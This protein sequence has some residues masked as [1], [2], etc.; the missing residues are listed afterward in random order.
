[1][2]KFY[3]IILI[4]F[5]AFTYQT[6][7]QNSSFSFSCVRDTT[8]TLCASSCFTLTARIPDIH[9]SSN[10]YVVNS[11]TSQPDGC[12]RQYIS[13]STPGTSTSIDMD[14]RYSDNIVLPFTF[15]FFGTDFTSL[16]ISGNGYLSLDPLIVD[17]SFSHW[18]ICDDG[19]GFLTFDGTP[20]DLPS[21]LYD[22][23]LIMGP[24]HDMDI[25]ENTSPNSRIKYDVV[26]VAPH[27]RWIVSYYKLPLYQGVSGTCNTLI[28]NTH[29]IVLYEGNGVVEVFVNSVENCPDW[30]LGRAMIGM[31]NYNRDQGIMAPGRAASDPSWGQ[32]NMNETW[33]FIPSAGPTL[34]RSTQLFNLAGTLISTGDTTNIGN[35][36]FQVAFPTVCPTDTTT[37]V[38]KTTYEQYNNPGVF[39]YSTD[40]VNVNVISGVAL[41]AVID[42]VGANCSN[43]GIGSATIT[44]TG[45]TGPYEYSLDGVTFQPSCGNLFYLLPRSWGFLYFY[46]DCY[47]FAGSTAGIRYLRC[48]KCGLFPGG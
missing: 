43:N 24:Y 28:E 5:L 48:C 33:R 36:T 17:G 10:S 15:P 13:D 18:G 26:G 22:Q 16:H 11:V 19:T 30:N 27:R 47:Y 32:I 37:Y 40:T 9:A 41:S 8:V 7:A 31:Q 20:V 23:A 38:V 29:Q 46:K 35:N 44:V 34:Y 21:T 42:S 4:L 39:F 6:K 14:D 25:S 1:M 12:F 3:P 45:G 2:R